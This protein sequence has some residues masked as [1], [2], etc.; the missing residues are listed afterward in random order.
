[1]TENPDLHYGNLEQDPYVRKRLQQYLAYII[2]HIAHETTILDVGGYMGDMLLLLSQN[3]DKHFIYHLV[4]F[5]DK[6][7]EIAEQRG[8]Y[9]YKVHFDT[10]SI[11]KYFPG[12]QFDVILCTEVLE[13]L[14]DP[15]RH[16]AKIKE[17]LQDNGLCIISLP[18]ENSIFHRLMSVIG[19]GVDQCAFEL[20]K[21]LHLPTIAQSRKFVSRYFK[22]E[23]ISYYINPSL[24]GSRGSGFGKILMFFPDAFWDFLAATMPGLFARGV[25]FKLKKSD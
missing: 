5:D 16:L 9:T 18:N 7:L 22:I 10:E 12:K 14:L 8:A 20:Y 2:D 21:H 13:H 15:H 17:L 19:C 3:C 6:A 4:D 23:V 11:D 1:M 25:I 24:K